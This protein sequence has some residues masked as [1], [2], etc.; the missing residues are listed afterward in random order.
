MSDSVT[1]KCNT[2]EVSDGYHTFG[3]LYE[4]RIELWI[5][6]CREWTTKFPKG[7]VWRSPLHS[8]G[9][10][11][12]GWFVLGAGFEGDQ[13]TYH[14]PLSR[15]SDCEF[16][17]ERLMCPSFDGHTSADVLVRLRRFGAR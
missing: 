4:H 13:M 14:L 5:A 10:S 17:T 11:I 15:W 6:L 16:A 9:T 1:I 3:E 8:N 7:H 2:N 12:E